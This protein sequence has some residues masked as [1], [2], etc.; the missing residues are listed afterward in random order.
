[1]TRMRLDLKSTKMKNRK[2]E[3]IFYYKNRKRW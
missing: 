2:R 3:K 1:M